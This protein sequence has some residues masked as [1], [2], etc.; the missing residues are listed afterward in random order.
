MLAFGVWRWSRRG[1]T[2]EPAEA[3]ASGLDEETERRL[4]DVLARFE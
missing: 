2:E 4:D 3:P 1:E